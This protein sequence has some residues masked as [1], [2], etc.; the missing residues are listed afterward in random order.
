MDGQLNKEVNYRGMMIRKKL[1]NLFK[2]PTVRGISVLTWGGAI[3]A[4]AGLVSTL[5]ILDAL[6]EKSEYGIYAIVM[7]CAMVANEIID[8]RLHEL[9][10][11][12]LSRMTKTVTARANACL[13]FL[14][15]DLLKASCGALVL[16]ASAT[17]L[18]R[19]FLNDSNWTFAFV[20][21][22]AIY[23]SVTLSPLAQ[24]L[25]RY[26][27]KFTPI[28]LAIV[29]AAAIRL[30][31]TAGLYF[32]EALSL[33]AVL[34]V[35]VVFGLVRVL[36]LYGYLYAKA[37]RRGLGI[38]NVLPGARVCAKE[39]LAD[40]RFWSEGI[41]GSL[42]IKVRMLG[43]RSAVLL[44][45]KLSN[46]TVVADY[47][48]AKRLLRPLTIIAGAVQSV[49]YP[50]VVKGITEKRHD[51]A[52]SI[53]RWGWANVAVMGS[54]GLFLWAAA[55]GMVQQK[56]LPAKYGGALVPLG[57]FIAGHIVVSWF[58]WLRPAAYALGKLKLSLGIEAIAVALYL[59]LVFIIQ[60]TVGISAVTMAVVSMS[61]WIPA[62]VVLFIRFE[63]MMR[64]FAPT[65]C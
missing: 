40:K 6:K 26:Y 43:N 29:A 21:S 51:I 36:V 30:F 48:L 18:S 33:R 62:R 44:L 15:F 31:L 47:Y 25:C 12:N 57:I 24:S 58:F 53:R 17:V 28:A 41:F 38:T 8:P 7:T 46:I 19:F 65:L 42:G 63:R 27:E 50:R 5:F 16:A 37:V 60:V 9:V 59:L 4:G 64:G 3:S 61:Y 49:F 13:T 45:S 56:I 34:G 54:T 20:W 35:E 14:G 2:S 52:F 11:L 55:W 39:I 23:F 1:S 10:I 22:A 32:A